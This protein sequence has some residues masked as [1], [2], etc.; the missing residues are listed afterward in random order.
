ME[1]RWLNRYL[2]AP[3]VPAEPCKLLPKR[4]LLA[5]DQGSVRQTISLILKYDGYT[6]VE[7]TNGA[8][9]LALFQGDRFDLVITDFDMPIMKGNELASRIKQILPSQPIL[10]ITAYVEQLGGNDNPVDAILDKPFQ[11]EDLRRVMTELL[12]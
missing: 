10:M 1:A 4:I 9:A 6:V 5:D 2:A 7:A 3:G 12:S 11:L 8:E